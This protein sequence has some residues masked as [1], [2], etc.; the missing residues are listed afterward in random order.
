MPAIGGAYA[1]FLT[2]LAEIP[3]TAGHLDESL[4]AIDEA[5]AS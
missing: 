1:P 4:A 2:S 5:L 3:L